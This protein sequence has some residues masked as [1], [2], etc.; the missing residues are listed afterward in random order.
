L[1]DTWERN[2]PLEIDLDPES[3]A[4]P[5]FVQG[6]Q[7]VAVGTRRVL[8]IPPEWA[9]GPDGEPSLG[10]PAGTDL[11]VIVDVVGVF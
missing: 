7:C 3:G 1:L 10:L 2:G 8:T 9:F 6:L 5:G 4:I 11:I